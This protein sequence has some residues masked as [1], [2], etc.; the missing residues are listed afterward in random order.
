MALSLHGKSE[1]AAHIQQFNGEHHHLTDY[2]TQEI[3]AQQPPQIRDFLLQTAILD[4]FCIPLCQAVTDDPD[5]PAIMNHLLDNNL[6]LIPLDDDRTWFRYHNLFA[7][8]LRG[9]LARE[10]GENITDLYFLASQWCAENDLASEAIH[11]ALKSGHT[12][13]AANLILAAG[14]QKLRHGELTTLLTWLDAVSPAHLAQNPRLSL[15]YA[16]TLEHTC[17]MEG[18]EPHL[19]NVETVLNSVPY[20]SAEKRAMQGEIAALRARIAVLDHDFDQAITYSHD[21][22]ALIPLDNLELRTAV[23]FQLALAYNVIDD[24]DSMQPVLDDTI[25]A[26]HDVGDW[27]T[28]CFSANY[29]IQL[30]H[31][32]GH[33]HRALDLIRQLSTWAADAQALNLPAYG[34]IHAAHA[35]ILYDMNQLDAA[36]SVF[37]Q[38]LKLGEHGGEFHI[39]VKA[40]VG[41]AYTKI[42]QNDRESAAVYLEKA[43]TLTDGGPFYD[44]FRA[45]LALKQNDLQTASHWFAKHDL[46]VD[47]LITNPEIS[48]FHIPFIRFLIAQKHDADAER[49]LSALTTWATD[50]HLP[51]YTMRYNLLQAIIHDASDNPT[52]ALKILEPILVWANAENSRRL[53]LDEPL[54]T[55]LLHH[56]AQSH[57]LSAPIRTL[58]ADLLDQFPEIPSTLSPSFTL[59]EDLSSRELDI[60]PFLAAGLSNKAIADELYLSAGTVKWHLKSIYRKLDVHSR[61]QAVA[62]ARDLNL[63]R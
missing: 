46:S 24:V 1:P 53:F 6:F 22:L 34:F 16:W 36:E 35:T 49:L 12:N 63:I 8:H 9:Q 3:L 29:R 48:Y 18:V 17:V 55:S 15:L 30:Y 10:Q 7:D 33:L 27:R 32:H 2:F 60:L 42:A 31:L 52:R 54:A 14:P 37:L 38:A 47:A 4:R 51:Y 40:Y 19:R 57:T 23:N 44:I 58:L 61:T 21:A 59:F 13:H 41:L 20:S 43:S 26:A 50:H 45:T 25:T 62:T 5:S 39:L 28:L 56:A 11:Y